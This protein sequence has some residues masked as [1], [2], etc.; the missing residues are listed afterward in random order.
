[1][2]A[3]RFPQVFIID[4]AYVFRWPSTGKTISL[5]LLARTSP[6][7][8]TAAAEVNLSVDNAFAIIDILLN[9]TIGVNDTA[10]AAE[11]YAAFQTI[12]VSS[13][14]VHFILKGARYPPLAGA[15][16]IQPVGGKKQDIRAVQRSEAT[17]LKKFGIHADEPCQATDGGFPDG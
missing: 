16:L 13:N 12:T 11:L 10:P 9:R 14:Q 4:Q 15:L 8:I 3:Q 6:A 2:V 1:M 7:F 17:G 5:W